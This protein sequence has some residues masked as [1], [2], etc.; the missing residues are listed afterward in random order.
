M[1]TDLQRGKIG[2]CQKLTGCDGSFLLPCGRKSDNEKYCED[3][4]KI[5]LMKRDII[6][7]G[8]DI[9]I[10]DETFERIERAFKKR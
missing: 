10:T 9:Q 5:P 1:K 4:K 7:K 6:G 2:L 3:W 8:D